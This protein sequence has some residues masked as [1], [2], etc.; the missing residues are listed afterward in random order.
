MKPFIIK[1]LKQHIQLG[2]NTDTAYILG[3]K[4]ALFINEINKEQKL[5]K[6]LAILDHPR[7][8]QQYKSKQKH[9]YIDKYIIAL[10]K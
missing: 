7:Y 5:F 9:E 3:K 2:L 1:S 6:E 4:N 10:N 8:I